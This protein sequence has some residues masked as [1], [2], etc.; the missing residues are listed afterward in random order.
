MSSDF[1]LLTNEEMA[2]CDRLTIKG[3]TPGIELMEAAGQGIAEL[4]HETGEGAI[5]VLCGPGNNGGDGFVAAKLLKEWGRDV[6]LFLLGDLKSLKGDAALAAAK[7]DGPVGAVSPLAVHGADVIVDALFGAGLA[8]P[9]EGAA[10]DTVDA[11][12]GSSAWI[13]AVDVPSGLNGSTGE[14]QGPAVTADETITFFRAKLG[15]MLYPGRA[16]CGDLTVIDIGIP[17][18]VLETIRPQTIV[19]DPDLW[20]EHFP[21][22]QESAHKYARGHAIIVSGDELH[23]G[24]SRLAARAALRV[25]AGLVTMV[26]DRDALRIHAA[27]VTDIM[28]AEAADAAALSQLLKDERKNAV[29]IGPAAGVSI[30]T[31]AKTL[32]VLEAKRATILDAD[33]FTSFA[34]DPTALLKALHE[35]CVLTP[36]EGEFERIFPGLLKKSGGRLDAARAAAAKC[37]V[38]VLLKGPDTIV[39]APDGRV[40]VNVNA[41][42]SLATAGSGD[43]LAGLITGLLAQGVEVFTAAS[44]ATWIHGEAASGFGLG[45]VASDLPNL[46]PEVLEE[47][48]SGEDIFSET[49]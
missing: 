11:I 23:T 13:I 10:A 7:W 28:L 21:W 2:E 38:V 12:N 16:L 31:K 22:P 47:L 29:L 43:V 35:N 36:H 39:A 15:H 41:P 5:H 30:E 34:N 17:G 20:L 44:M 3:G 45:L 37:G 6:R 42:A 19:N 40:A 18:E 33:V 27:Q 25:G 8:R 4:A 46:V 14:V 49:P 26:G 9:L 32:A 1:A 48:A 24:A